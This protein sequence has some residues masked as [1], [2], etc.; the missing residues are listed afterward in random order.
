MEL[1]YITAEFLC[2][3]FFHLAP[4]SGSSGTEALSEYFNP[5]T[6]REGVRCCG[7][8]HV[9]NNGNSCTSMAECSMSVIALTSLSLTEDATCVPFVRSSNEDELN[10][11]AK[12]FGFQ[13][14]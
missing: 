13:R 5:K 6:S 9:V 12:L 1:D 4:I 8:F 2:C 7:H 11:A 14:N 10:T 3:V